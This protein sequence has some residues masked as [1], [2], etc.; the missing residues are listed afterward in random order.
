M[1]SFVL[2]ENEVISL[3]KKPLGV[4]CTYVGPNNAVTATEENRCE[5]LVQ[6]NPRDFLA[7]IQR[8]LSLRNVYDEEIKLS[9]PCAPYQF[10]LNSFNA[11]NVSP[12]LLPF[13]A[14]QFPDNNA[15]VSQAGEKERTNV[16]IIRALAGALQ[17]EVVAVRET[18]AS[19]LGKFMLLR[20]RN[21][22]EDKIARPQRVWSC[23]TFLEYSLFV[24]PSRSK[25]TNFVCRSNKSAGRN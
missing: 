11:Y 19:S 5:G 25:Q 21:R 23:D 9:H 15:A 4:M 6:V 2:D 12:A 22:N 17:D 8:L 13:D 1:I 14:S 7:A 10:L 18:A 16:A 20:W 24:F 3:S